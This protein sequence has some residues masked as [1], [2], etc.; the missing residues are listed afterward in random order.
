MRLSSNLG[1]SLSRGES[2]EDSSSLGGVPLPGASP[3]VKTQTPY[4]ETTL[5][6]PAEAEPAQDPNLHVRS[7]LDHYLEMACPPHFAVLL[8]GPWGAG[9]THF[10]RSVLDHRYDEQTPYAYVSLYGLTSVEE[11]DRALA[12]ALYPILSGK[13]RMYAGH[14]VKA[15]A[16]FLRI[17]TELTLEQIV[18]TDKAAVY[19][20]DDLERCDMPINKALGYINALVEHDGKKVI[21]IANEAAIKDENYGAIREKLIGKTLV[22]QSVFKEALDAFVAQLRDEAARIFVAS[23]RELVRRVYVQSGLENLRMLQQALWEFERVFG[24]LDPRQRDSAAA[25][26]AAFALILVYSF[27]LRADRL[28]ADHLHARFARRVTLMGPQAGA[29]SPMLAANDRYPDIDLFDRVLDDETLYAVLVQGLVDSA[30]IRRS[31]N[32]STYLRPPQTTP[33]WAIVW[34]FLQ[35]PDNVVAKA[36]AEME[37]KFAGREY[38]VSGEI[39]HVF[40]LRLWGASE[41]R[42]D[43]ATVEEVLIECRAYLAALAAAGSIVPL[44]PQDL[45]S[46]DSGYGGFAY[47][48]DETPE[49][50]ELADEL[51]RL[52]RQATQNFL[53]AAAGQLVDQMASDPRLFAQEITASYGNVPRFYDA[54]ILASADRVRFVELFFASDQESQYTIVNALGARYRNGRLFTDLVAERDW[55]QSLVDELRDHAGG[56]SAE[57]A[58]RVR[59]LI[60]WRL[61]PHLK[62]PGDD[63]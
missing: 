62:T 18:N 28:K 16:S 60:D 46:S 58:F 34:N 10:V 55:V 11:I 31:F 63:A 3:I 20:F 4:R 14:A 30:Q 29:P 21:L 50:L 36:L 15:A 7:Y 52:G 61:A 56:L 32:Q 38:V 39:L 53:P 24:V 26:D 22:L 49:F 5:T 2:L 48:A 57:G 33:E 47:M 8:D 35:H 51:R 42:Y 17:K 27:E 23:R 1:R 6:K 40:G 37:R 41:G 25:M 45:G 59:K 13:G 44:S 9:K 19:V 43:G 54:P 12:H